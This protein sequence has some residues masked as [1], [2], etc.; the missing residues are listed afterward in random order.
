MAGPFPLLLSTAVQ[1]YD[2]DAQSSGG[3]SGAATNDTQDGSGSQTVGSVRLSFDRG[4]AAASTFGGL[5][6]DGT[7]SLQGPSIFSLNGTSYQLSITQALSISSNDEVL[8]RDD[9]TDTTYIARAA[10]NV[11]LRATDGDGLESAP[12]NVTILV[13]VNTTGIGGASVDRIESDGPEGNLATDGSSTIIIGGV[14]LDRITGSISVSYGPYTATGCRVVSEVQDLGE[15]IETIQCNSRPGHGQYHRVTII[16]Q[17]R[18]LRAPQLLQLSYQPPA[19]ELVSGTRGND[20][21]G[22][23]GLDVQRLLTTGGQVVYLQGTGFANNVSAVSVMYGPENP[24]WVDPDSI[25]Q[26]DENFDPLDPEQ[27]PRYLFRTLRADVI[28]VINSEI[29]VR[30]APGLGTGLGWMVEVDGQVVYGTA[31]TEVSYG[32]AAISGIAPSANLA[33]SRFGLPTRGSAGVASSRLIVSG[34]NFGP[35]QW[36]GEDV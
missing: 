17:G 36:L 7:T 19:L 22:E 13:T 1:V 8:V 10:Y 9:A 28:S 16:A 5:L 30:T 3:D 31:Q 4:S 27:N 20:S 15:A 26:P 29:A 21:L 18:E 32:L 23:T 34:H 33:S 11:Q 14:G 2:E 35:M 12:R 25:A 24:G 6:S